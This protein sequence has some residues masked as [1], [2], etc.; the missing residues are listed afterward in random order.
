MVIGREVRCLAMALCMLGGAVAASPARGVVESADGRVGDDYVPAMLSNGRLCLFCDYTL[1]VPRQQTRYDKKKLSTGIS[2]EGRRLGDNNGKAGR[3]GFSLL[4]QG[5]L[6]TLLAVDGV[7]QGEPSAWRQELDVRKA[8]TVVAAEHAGGVR[9]DGEM[10]VP[11]ARNLIAMKQTVTAKDAPREVTVGIVFESPG[12]ERIVGGWTTDASSATWKMTAYARFV[13]HETIVVRAADGAPCD[14]K[15]VGGNAELTRKVRLAPGE[16]RTF[17]WYVTY[18][19]DLASQLPVVTPAAKEDGPLPDYAALR[20]AHV[21][22]WA[23]Y[24]AESEIDVPDERIKA[25]SDMARYHL[26]CNATEWSIPVGI[27]PGHWH[28]RIFAF[29]EMY[30]VQGLLSAGHFST[31]KIAP[32]F[33]FAT[34][35]NACLQN[36]KNAANPFYSHGARWVWEGAEGNDVESGP[37]G[38]WQDH[39]FHSAA[40]AQTVWTYYRYTGDLAYLKAKGYDVLR[41]CALFF[42]RMRVIDMPDGTS[43]V[44]KCTDL[45]RMGPGRD[46][47]FMTTCGVIATLRAAAS[48]ADLV[49]K[50]AE[51]AADF[52]D[53][54]D[55]LV[56]SLP[57][58]DGRYIPYP[59]CT[60]ESMGSL[61]G[62]Y[63]FQVFGRESAEQVAATRHFLEN[64]E[65][66][67][68]MYSTGKRICPWYAATMAMASLRSGDGKYPP[69][70]WLQ[71]AYRSAG[72]WGEYWEI[73]EPG[74]SQ[75]RP[76]FMTAAGNCLYAINQL[77]VTERDGALHLASGVPTE[78]RDFSFR[79]PAPGG[80]V[81]RMKVAGGKLEDVRL[82][83]SGP[84]AKKPQVVIPEW[85][86]RTNPALCRDYAAEAKDEPCR[87]PA[88]RANVVDEVNTGIGSISH[89]LVPTL[90]T[91]QRP[92]AQF[93]FN[94]PERQYTEDRVSAVGLHCPS[95]RFRSFFPVQPYAGPAD[96]VFGQWSSTWDQEHATP[97][98]YDI[99]LDTHGVVFSIAPGE[100]SAI[101]SF[102]FERPGPH[103]LVFGLVDGK[104]GPCRVEGKV[105]RGM[106]VY[107]GRGRMYLHGEFDRTPTAVKVSG[108]RTAVF[109]GEGAETVKMRFAISYIS[110]EQAARNLAAEVK[111]FDLE[112]LAA[113]AKRRW[114]EVLGQIEVEGGTAA[115][116]RVFYTALWRCYERM[117]NVTEDGKYRGFDGQVHETGGVDYYTDDWTWDTYRAAHP[118]MTILRPKEEAAKLASYVRM[119]EQN[120]EKWMPVFPSVCHDAHCM[121]NRHPAIMFLDAWRKGIRG[122]D[123]RRAFELMDHTE[124]T[125]SLIPWY[126]GPLT[127]LDRFY[128]EHG[129]YPAIR[130]EEKETVKGVNTSWERR[131][132]VS[133]TQGAS[134]DAWALSELGREIGMDAGTV[135][136]YAKRAKDYA[137]L[138][139]PKTQFFHPKDAEGKF[140]EP[141]DYMICGGYG[142][143]HYYTENNAW[144]YIWDVQHDLPGLLSLFGGPQAMS[145][146]M[147]AMLNA[148]VGRRWEFCAK[149]PDGCTG[150]M[151]VFTMANE[152]SFHIPYLYNYTGEPWKTQ[153]F[154][155][156]TLDCW[157]RDDRMG[158]CGDE[159]GGGMS[160][161]AVF[162]M[163]GFYPVTPGLPEYQLGSPVFPKVT[164]HL[165][166]GKDFVLAAPGA[167]ADAKY[168]QSVEVDGA[169]ANGT[170]VLKH[171]DVAR[172]AR[173]TI[174]MGTRPN[175][176]WGQGK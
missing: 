161:Y 44:T 11:R 143:R 136:K 82:E 129:Y 147:D 157:F 168:V 53:C 30:G 34:L 67:G 166:N 9:L 106:D 23:A 50:D 77:F 88:A 139:N 73:N 79:L 17:A 141:F 104:D 89:M 155:R 138:W 131:Q 14:V 13:T 97:Y 137:N 6:A 10:F 172:G 162:S 113:A 54:A 84:A 148:N 19:D 75:F 48:A 46:H 18:A 100:K 49:G 92:N 29:D 153:K 132:T 98:R 58:K 32:D 76:W 36:N 107:A 74:V 93:R 116:R 163:L 154:V 69:V 24:F 81:V 99:W 28:G 39:I 117:V 22:D 152:P 90:R 95:H 83:P 62:F 40:V 1:S 105:L 25:M 59:G 115:E 111:D 149:M 124:E 165:E 21:A 110:P 133:V 64:G 57:E 158:M 119:A 173:V 174:R 26:R 80:L 150:L 94:A 130:P 56:K 108:N 16:S 72:C 35:R 126:R 142:A 15:I 33:R 38:Y 43:F 159:D 121:V 151:G 2:W 4:P 170:T 87:R 175:K 51:L 135:A 68:N 127:E 55:R 120:E 91:V 78:W 140:I 41:E 114:N 52:R 146:K 45:E 156:K 167:S 27:I 118:L 71:E 103:A 169:A 86:S 85:L 123:V 160:A 176:S 12:S 5:R 61:A 37:I 125:E 8:L 96:G 164:I 102:A 145:R 7:R 171:A 122:Y 65:A 31:A 63:P 47:A 144:T 128:K 134:Y 109:F 42:R 60:D 112:A 3:F 70:R 101:A 20:A 66:F